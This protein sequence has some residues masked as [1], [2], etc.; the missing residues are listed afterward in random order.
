MKPMKSLPVL[1]RRKAE[2]TKGMRLSLSAL[3]EASM[4][5]DASE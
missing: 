4:K 2:H 1:I 5:G 3:C